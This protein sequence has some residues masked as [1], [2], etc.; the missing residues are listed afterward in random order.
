MFRTCS[1]SLT[2]LMLMAVLIVPALADDPAKVPPQPPNPPGTGP[3][4]TQLRGLFHQW[5]LNSDNYLDKEELAKA[6]GYHHAYDYQPPAK[7]DKK[8]NDKPATADKKDGDKAAKNDAPTTKDTPAKNGSNGSRD[9]SKRLDYQFLKALDKDHDERISY[10][11][12]LQWARSYAAQ[13][14]RAINLQN[15]LRRAEARLAV[16]QTVA[17]QRKARAKIRQLHNKLNAL[18]R[19]QNAYT[20]QIQRT[21]RQ[22]R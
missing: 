19:A 12:F 10:P 20:R 14:K 21:I 9:H 5:D 22:G 17:A 13:L 6:F 4:M 16:A 3:I 18:N 15:R 8:E 11:E 2:S 1:S 7:A